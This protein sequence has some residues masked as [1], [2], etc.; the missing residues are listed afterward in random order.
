MTSRSTAP[1]PTTCKGVL[2]ITLGEAKSSKTQ[3]SGDKQVFEFNPD[4]GKLLTFTCQNQLKVLVF[5][6]L[7]L[8]MK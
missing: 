8:K 5:S 4:D 2:E 1:L 6:K 7:K 3:K